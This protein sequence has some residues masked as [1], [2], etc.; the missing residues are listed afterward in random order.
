MFTSLTNR[1][2]RPFGLELAN[3]R[4]AESEFP[5]D[6][7]ADEIETIAMVSAYS[8][9]SPERLY[10]LIHAVSYVVKAGIPGDIVECGVWRGGSMMAVA[11]T[12]IKL[13]K[14]DMNLWLYDT[15]EGMTKPTDMDVSY[16]GQKATSEFESVKRND[17]SSKWCYSSLDEVRGNLL[18]VGYEESRMRFVKGTVEET[19]PATAPDRI[20]LLRLDTDW[21]ESTKHE[22]EYLFPRLSPGGVLII[23]DYGHW[24]G[25]RKACDDYFAAHDITILLNRID[26]TGRIAIKS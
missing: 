17:A 9:T 6:F 24:Q 5:P 7:N 2:L 14:R 21:Y 16:D 1:L 22:L 3:I 18:Q 15:F 11:R 20:S 12:L 19:I 26:Y 25:S 10:S 8:M 13:N 4:G 23:D